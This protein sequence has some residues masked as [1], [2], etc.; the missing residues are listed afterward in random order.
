MQKVHQEQK[1]PNKWHNWIYT[2]SMDNILYPRR[3]KQIDFSNQ[4]IITRFTYDFELFQASAC[5]TIL[6]FTSG[7]TIFQGTDVW[8]NLR[9]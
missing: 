8:Q 3:V 2:S 7:I 4:E 5:Q 6:W 1:W 9:Y